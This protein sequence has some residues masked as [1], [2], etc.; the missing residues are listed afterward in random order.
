MGMGIKIRDILKIITDPAVLPESTVDGLE[1]G[2]PD[3]V[4]KGV[5]VMFMAT[6]QAIE[7]AINLGD[8][9]VISH[10]GIFFSH[11]NRRQLL[12]DDPVYLEKCRLI[13]N[14]GIAV[15]RY[16]DY[17]HRTKPDCITAGLLKSLK[18]EKY[19]TKSSQIA[20]ILEVPSIELRDVIEHIKKELKVPYVRVIGDMSMP[21]R[22]IGI[23]VGYRGSG[24]SVIPL[25]SEEDP[26]LVI[27]G[28]G[29]EWETPE[30]V[31]DAV[32]QG[33]HKALIVIGHAESEMPGM[34]F[35]ARQIKEKIPEL[36]V[37]FIPQ[38]PIFQVC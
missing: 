25:F 14:N 16:H 2:D 7:Q 21:C 36:P 19:E 28:E 27:Y 17:V 11:W 29:P 18:W 15:Y 32:Q 5:A 12:K 3:L 37:H 33:R 34:E 13:E 24:E 10:E 22:R 8:N 9:F 20:S 23:L 1:F 31:R 30:Y 4:V 26:D 38:E 35:V 6:H